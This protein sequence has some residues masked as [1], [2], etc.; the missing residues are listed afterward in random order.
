MA[1]GSS[2]L[3]Y[4]GQLPSRLWIGYRAIWTH[5]IRSG[6]IQRIQRSELDRINPDLRWWWIGSIGRIAILSGCELYGAQ[7]QASE[8]LTAL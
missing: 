3:I 5:P 7:A 1:C 6:S 2:S 4:E 8:H